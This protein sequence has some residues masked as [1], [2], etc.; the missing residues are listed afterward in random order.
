MQ[1]KFLAK[2]TSASFPLSKDFQARTVLVGRLDQNPISSSNTDQSK[3]IL[4]KEDNAPEVL[5]M[6]NV[7]PTLHGYKSVSFDT[8]TEDYVDLGVGETF[9]YA[10]S[11]RTITTSAILG[12]TSTGRALLFSGTGF[13]IWEDI[14][15]VG[16]TGS[17][18]TTAF[19]QGTLYICYAN[20]DVFSVDL[21]NKQ[22]VS[23]SLLGITKSNIIGITQSNSYLIIHDGQ[24]I[25]W[26][27]PLN[28]LDFVPSLITGA[29]S[30]IPLG[31]KGSIIKLE[32]IQNGFA[33]YSSTNIAVAV[34]SGNIRYPWIFA[35]A[36]NSSGIAN[37][38]AVSTSGDDGTNYAWTAAGLLKVSVRGCNPFLP[39]VTDFLTSRLWEEFDIDSA[40]FSTEFLTD[41]LNIALT[42]VSARYLIISYGRADYEYALIYDITL[43]RLGKIKLD[44]IA[45]IDFT[46]SSQKDFATFNALAAITFNDLANTP[47]S[48]LYAFTQAPTSPK[49]TIAF[50]NS[51]GGIKL[52]NFDIGDFTSTSV[53]VLGKYQLVREKL[54]TV[55]EIDVEGVYPDN[56]NFSLKILPS[57]DGKNFDPE[58]VPYLANN[59]GLLRS[60]LS[61]VT[62]RNFSLIISGSFNLTSL[63]IA[64]S[65]HGNR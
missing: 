29:G 8:I 3:S 60:Y 33:I 31:L 37:I 18:I 2:L 21:V 44:H 39:E 47:F 57:L 41:D 25:Y 17:D 22:M 58:L 12:I 59:S 15:P 11:L 36:N 5:Y 56:D 43:R 19:V 46:L 1:Y 20:F 64:I 62:A 55:Q 6:E 34:Y 32:E 53:L 45:V 28:P 40:E 7:L 9:T 51:N 14:T 35:E 27:S 52:A 23:V 24:T 30:G 4:E 26:S 42:F 54:I 61:L 38:S 63:Q 50:V 65:T 48:E 10:I 16:A 13:N 49:K